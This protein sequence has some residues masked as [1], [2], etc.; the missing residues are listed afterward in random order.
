MLK[1]KKAIYILIPLNLAIWGYFIYRICGAFFGS[2][3]LPNDERTEILKIKELRD[4][5]VYK[6]SLDYKDPFLREGEKQRNYYAVNSSDQS[7]KRKETEKL[8]AVKMQ[9]VAIAP[10]TPLDL[11]YYGLVKNSTTGTSTA[12][13]ALN[14]QSKLI[15]VN[16]ILEGI[17]FKSFNKDSLV[18]KNGKET[19]VV[20]R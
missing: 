4:S 10:K 2:D 16:D 9:T 1:N 8:K 5:I 20:R 15:K 3:V 19:I 18:A 11:R 13:V 12:L 17:T 6:L 7:I 14:G